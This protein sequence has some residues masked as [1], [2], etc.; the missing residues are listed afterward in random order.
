MLSCLHPSPSPRTSLSATRRAWTSWSSG[1]PVTRSRSQSRARRRTFDWVVNKL[2]SSNA[3]RHLIVL[4]SFERH[5]D[6]ASTRA[7][8]SGD[9]PP[10][11]PAVHEDVRGRADERGVQTC[12]HQDWKQVRG[13]L[14]ADRVIEAARTAPRRGAPAL[15]LAT[16]SRALLVGT[17]VTTK[18][19]T[20]R[21]R[22]LS[23]LWH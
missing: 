16:S 10:R 11:D 3:D 7:Q 5:I 19:V 2:S 23:P 22:S 15:P 17:F 21:R 13:C 8:S 18:A 14:V 12:G 4:V 9:S 1:R 6:D 20:E